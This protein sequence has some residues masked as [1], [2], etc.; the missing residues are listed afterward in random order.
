MNEEYNDETKSKSQNDMESENAADVRLTKTEHEELLRKLKDAEALQE[1]MLRSAADFDNAKKRL[2]K[3]KEDYFKFA[4]EGT[5][6]ELLPVLDNFERALAHR[7]DDPAQKALWSGIE[8]I[9]KHLQE[10]LK[11]RGL[12][13]METLKEPFDPHLHESIGHVFSEKEKEGN[14]AE[15]VVA[16]YLLN[17]KL[18][19]PAKVKVFTREQVEEEKEEQIT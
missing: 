19:R 3:E 12:S 18:L 6:Y 17:G 15:E 2:T 4:L 1:R 16:G 7:V 5:L 14:V 10:V 13:R 8:L 9:H 11:S